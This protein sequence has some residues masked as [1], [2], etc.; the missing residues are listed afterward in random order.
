MI[1]IECKGIK[2]FYGKGENRVI[3]LKGIN[4]QIPAG[5][6]T[7]LVGPSGSGKTTLLSI[8]D[9]ILTPDEG[10]LYIL[11]HHINRMDEKEKQNLGIKTLVSFSSLCI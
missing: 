9:T 6:L 3:A 2:K 11:G 1:T 7:L 10:D 4:L 8:I 5:E